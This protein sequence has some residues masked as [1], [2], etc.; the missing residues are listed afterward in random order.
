[1]VDVK[2]LQETF[3]FRKEGY[4]RA[5]GMYLDRTNKSHYNWILST[6]AIAFA[7]RRDIT[8]LNDYY[9]ELMKEYK[10]K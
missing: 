10:I 9:L 4:F 7:N 2:S 5:S 8:K 3:L 6:D 1:M